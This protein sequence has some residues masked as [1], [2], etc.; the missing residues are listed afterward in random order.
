[1]IWQCIKMAVKAIT[2]NKV[3]A[4][5]TMLGI[6]I[7][8][9]ALVV[10]ISLAESAQ[11]VVNDELSSLGTNMLSV[12]ISGD[13]I[14]SLQLSDISE[15]MDTPDVGVIA[16]VSTTT[17]PIKLGRENKYAIV[18][19]TNSAFQLI[20]KQEVEY[21]RFL[22]ASDLDNNLSVAVLEHDGAVS[23]F[24]NASDAVGRTFSLGGREFTVV[25]VLRKSDSVMTS[26]MSVMTGG[27]VTVYAPF[28][29]VGRLTGSGLS[30]RNFYATAEDPNKINDVE[31]I[32]GNLLLD[33]FDKNQDAFTVTNVSSL[34]TVMNTVTKIFN[35]LLGG[36][37]G[38]SLLVG[39][40]GIMNIM[41]VSV[42]ERTREIGIR[43]AIGANHFSIMIQFL[44]EA[45]LL[46]VMGCIA[47]IFF[48]W[49]ILSFV[50]V[51]TEEYIIFRLSGTVVALSVTFAILIGVIF[52]LY[53]AEK[54]AKMHP[55]EALRHE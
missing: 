29:T 37:S 3:R 39:G 31:F 20:Q 7:G 18:Y 40:I 10:L 43:K 14:R 16:P 34:L 48:S 12:N 26:M 17:L 32:I 47:G 55:I 5:L 38:I 42:S 50:N 46:S 13:G 4:F 2:S 45:L 25:G 54:A 36:I 9:V 49:L 1:M 19:G 8:V 22:K 52:G 44:I 11:S 15:Y 53:P 21:G 24:G 33:H 28:T 27:I 51:F 30:V 23:L 41:L 35:I 6:I